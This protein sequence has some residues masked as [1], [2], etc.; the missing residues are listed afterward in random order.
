MIIGTR[1]CAS[2]LQSESQ[3]FYFYNSLSVLRLLLNDCKLVRDLTSS[4]V[5]FW[6]TSLGRFGFSTK[7]EITN[8]FACQRTKTKE[9]FLVRA[10]EKED[11]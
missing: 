11:V 6:L 7:K 9:M 2:E 8:S 3:K 5:H 1:S 10:F 4:K